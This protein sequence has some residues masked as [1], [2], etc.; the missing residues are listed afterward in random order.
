MNNKDRKA[1]IKYLLEKEGKSMKWLS[2]Q[3]GYK[4]QSSLTALFKNKKTLTED[5]INELLK[6]LGYKTEVSIEFVKEEK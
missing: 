4:D 3:L 2:E 6:P 5:K 1:D